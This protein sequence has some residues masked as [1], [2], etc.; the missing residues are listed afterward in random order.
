MLA[1]HNICGKYRHYKNEKLYEVIGQAR[2]SE[3]D[4][5]MIVYKALYHCAKFGD[6]QLWVRPMQ[7][8][9]EN[10]LHN[11]QTVPRFQRIE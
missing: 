7:M 9:F 4:E 5:E 6:N 1:D 11:D 10:V 3:T 8:F 2:H